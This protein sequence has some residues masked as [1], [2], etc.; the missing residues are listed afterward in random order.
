M[1]DKKDKPERLK[2][3]NQEKEKQEHKRAFYTNQIKE[4]KKLEKLNQKEIKYN[5]GW[6]NFHKESISKHKETINKTAILDEK[7]D[8]ENKLK[9]IMKNI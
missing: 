7:I 3:L 8:Q 1:E 6:I 4:L 5:E 9:N 2:Y